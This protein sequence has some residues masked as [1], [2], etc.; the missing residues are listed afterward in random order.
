M[1]LACLRA[2]LVYH[3]LNTAY[4]A[5]EL[6]FFLG[7]ATPSLVVCDETEVDLMQGLAPGV[8]L[9]TLNA[10]GSGTLVQDLDGCS[11]KFAVCQRAAGDLAALLYSSG[12]TGLPKG[13]MLTHGN[14]LSNARALVEAWGFTAGDCLL[15]A[16]PIYHVHGLFVATGCV[17]LSGARMRWHKRFNARPVADQLAQCSVF[18]GVPTYYTRLLGLADF[19]R[20]TCGDMRL[21]ISG[22]AP[23]LAETFDEFEARTGHCILE[24][25]GMT[26][27]NM[28]TSNP[29]LGQRK[30]GTVGPP[31]PGVDLRV[32]DDAGEQLARGVT[33]FLQVRGANVFAGYWNLP[34]KTFE[35]FSDDGYF[36]TG[37]LASI[38]ADGYVI[39]AGR[40]GDMI[41]SGGLNIY[42][43]ELET[44]IDNMPGVLESAVIGVPHPDL[45]EAVV[46]VVVATQDQQPMLES[47]RA[48]LV[49]QLA[50]FK[51]PK[52]TILTESLPRNF[53]G[54]VITKQLRAKY[55][56]LFT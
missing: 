49:E 55:S 1:Y 14:L 37:D 45:G 53:M 3:P 13:I 4:T 33:G 28:N 43:R 29:L 5:R 30:P 32:V 7:D 22:S 46:A 20:Q 35:A 42:P 10:G 52:H 47:I 41:I 21:F 24:R 27:T 18:M 23:L 31:L 17:M 12:T 44:L 16:L 8:R 48:A 51:R 34:D 26:E 50:G 2:G 25:Y 38:D 6:A 36:N 11:D 40:A 54:K 15:H 56:G 39:I 9:L 19:D